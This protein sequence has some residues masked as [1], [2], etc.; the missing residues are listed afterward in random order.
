MA[1]ATEAARLAR[2]EAGGHFPLVWPKAATA[3]ESQR[4]APRHFRAGWLAGGFMNDDDS[5][6]NDGT[7]RPGGVAEAA[8]AAPL[9]SDLLSGGR[10]GVLSAAEQMVAPI[11]FGRA[12]PIGAG[13]RLA[14]PESG[15]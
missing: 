9:G 2:A 15:V 3:V 5:M 1:A 8:A 11:G 13:R 12:L 7:G 6:K 10:S 4:A 14:R